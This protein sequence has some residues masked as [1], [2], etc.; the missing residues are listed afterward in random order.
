MTIFYDVIFLLISLVYLPL[1]LIRRKFHRGFIQRIGLLPRA[2]ELHHPIWI[3][4]VSVGE[5]VMVRPLLEE[6]RRAYPGKKFVIST[7][8]PTGNKIARQMAGKDDFVTYLPLDFSFVVK[9]VISRVKPSLF[10]IAET[11]LW[12]NL[13]LC[14]HAYR[15]PVVVVNGRIS[16]ASFRGYR[17]IR[18]LFSALFNRV[19]LFSVQTSRDRDRLI[20]LGVT[21]DKIRVAG[22]MKFDITADPGRDF[23]AYRNALG[24]VPSQKLIVAGS[25]HPQ[26]EEIILAVYKELLLTHPDTRLIIAPRHPERALEIEKLIAGF[27]FASMKISE[28]ARQPASA[29]QRPVFIL[30]TV[31]HLMAYYAIADI[32]FVGG[33]LTQ[34]GGH[35][36]LEPAVFG[37]PILFG[38][39]MFNFRDIA[40]LFLEEGAALL[41]HGKE[42]L[43]LRMQELLDNP[44]RGSRLGERARELIRKN[45]GATQK[46]MQL[47]RS[48]QQ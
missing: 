22:N 12:P 26:E 24:L 37:K 19:T 7:V 36:I 47:I 40:R 1:Y 29:G 20:A 3:H 41:V 42:E 35:N 2:L 16:D 46:N 4:A 28:V 6:L 48:L 14:L 8:T 25:T 13:I 39:H 15:I 10:I 27:G 34:K 5:A 44:A 43:S 32:V 31:G 30:D 11:E 38:P 33:S 23:S 18:F 45:Q 21:S 17:A 9:A